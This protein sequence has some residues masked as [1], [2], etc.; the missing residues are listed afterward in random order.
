MGWHRVC[1]NTIVR[2]EKVLDSERLRILPMG[3]RVNVVE[4]SGRRV[5]IDQPIVGWCSLNSSNGD[6][7]LKPLDP[8]SK[9]NV[10]PTPRSGQAAVTNLQ[11]RVNETQA[12]IEKGGLDKAK[13]DELNAEKAN[14]E[15]RLAEVEAKNRQ[16]QKVL[17]DW[18][19][20]AKSNA[21]TTADGL[22]S[23]DVQKIQFRNGDCLLL[24]KSAHLEGIVLVRCV[25][26]DSSGKEIIGCDYK[27]QLPENF[28]GA[29]DGTLDGKQL[30]KI[31][32]GFSGVWLERKDFKGLLPTLP[33]LN[34]LEKIEQEN[35]DLTYYK[36]TAE[37][38]IQ[39][40]K[41]MGKKYKNAPYID[42]GDGEQ[43]EG[44]KYA[45]DFMNKFTKIQIAD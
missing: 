23:T 10:A 42:L 34:R 24:S 14:L 39:V 28:A 1:L 45:A 25:S 43:I 2:K 31:P 33:L 15:A 4:K 13:L 6:T 32:T 38:F 16:Q 8:N 37:A 44:K 17:E 18:E 20:A 7:I 35:T 5:R 22:F 12:K 9:Q 30:W 41:D 26:K 21:S 19:S 36:D 27:G 40:I 11:S 29:S 3:S